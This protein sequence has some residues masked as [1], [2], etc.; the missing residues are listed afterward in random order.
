MK[1]SQLEANIC[2][3]HEA[4]ENPDSQQATLHTFLYSILQFFKLS[5]LEIL[6]MYLVFFLSSVFKLDA[7]R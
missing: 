7:C 6:H 1:Q 2:S 3:L 5:M 4:Q